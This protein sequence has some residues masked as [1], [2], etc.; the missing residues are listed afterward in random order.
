MEQPGACDLKSRDTA[1]IRRHCIR[2]GTFTFTRSVYALRIHGVT[3][4]VTD[5]VEA[6]R[7]RV[8][9]LDYLTL[10]HLANISTTLQFKGLWRILRPRRFSTEHKGLVV[11]APSTKRKRKTQV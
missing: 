4:W 11:P 1:A 2:W 6:G 3:S 8:T 7:G 5:H 9:F 10:R